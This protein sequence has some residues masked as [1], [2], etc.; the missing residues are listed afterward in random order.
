[1]NKIPLN[2]IFA[3]HVSYCYIFA[4]HG[5][6]LH[7][8]FKYFLNLKKREKFSNSMLYIY[9]FIVFVTDWCPCVD[10]DMPLQ[11]TEIYHYVLHAVIFASMIIYLCCFILSLLALISWCICL[12]WN[13]LQIQI[14]KQIK[15]LPGIILRFQISHI[16]KL[17]RQWCNIA[18]VVY[19]AT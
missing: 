19:N 12:E 18:I 13:L 9:Y 14:F 3:L 1:M 8:I 6:C 11:Y 5:Y 15:T 10:Y 17:S 16:S 4:C 2:D 7:S